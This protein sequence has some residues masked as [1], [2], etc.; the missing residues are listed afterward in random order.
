MTE[1]KLDIGRR[2]GHA[3]HLFRR[4][5]DEY[6]AAASEGVTEDLLSGRNVWVLQY[7]K[8][9]EGSPVY[10]RDLEEEFKIRRSTI[11]RMID[12]ME[13]KGLLRKEPV[14]GGDA[15]LRALSLTPKAEEIL[16]CV[17]RDTKILDEEIK[18]ALSPI[19]YARLASLLDRLS[20]ILENLPEPQ[21]KENETNP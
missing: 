12:L 15:R 6:V 11:S 14:A 1:R 21:R 3:S 7:L 13:Q 10:Q 2:I 16:A 8:D 17:S 9:H 5:I 19:D 4:R 18:K 20:D